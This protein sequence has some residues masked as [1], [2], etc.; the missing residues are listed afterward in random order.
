MTRVLETS[1]PVVL[2]HSL[3][4]G[5]AMAIELIQT[6]QSLGRDKAAAEAG[7]RALKAVEARQAAQHA[8]DADTFWT[9]C[10]TAAIALAEW[11]VGRAG[12]A[13]AAW[14]A[15][16][17][18]RA[19]LSPVRNTAL[20]ALE[21]DLLARSWDIDELAASNEASRA[22][23]VSPRDRG[24][25]LIRVAEA[26]LYQVTDFVQAERYHKMALS[27][28]GAAGDA[29][30][31]PVALALDVHGGR[32][33]DARA[34]VS[35]L[36]DGPAT[37]G[38]CVPVL[39]EAIRLELDKGLDAAALAPQ[40]AAP[41]A[42]LAVLQEVTPPTRRLVLLDGLERCPRW[43]NP[44]TLKEIAALLP[45]VDARG[46]AALLPKARAEGQDPAVAKLRLAE[47]ERVSGRDDHAH[48]LIDQ[49]AD[50]AR[51][52]GRPALLREALRARDRLSWTWEGLQAA[53]ASLAEM[54]KVDPTPA[55]EGLAWLEQAE[56]LVKAAGAAPGQQESSQALDPN[57]AGLCLQW[58]EESLTT[59]AR[60]LDDP[61]TVWKAR[62]ATARARLAAARGDVP[63]TERAADTAA[64]FWRAMGN[65]DAAQ[66]VLS[67]KLAPPPKDVP[68]P[69]VG[70]DSTGR[71][72]PHA[73]LQIQEEQGRRLSLTWLMPDG[74]KLS[75]T[76]RSS[77]M[78]DPATGL[79]EIVAN[80]RG[81]CDQLS[82]L[83]LEG[84]KMNVVVDRP[85][86][87]DLELVTSQRLAWLPWE[88]A[89]LGNRRW[90]PDA[91]VH[92]LWRS[93]HRAPAAVE[94]RGSEPCVVVFSQLVST[95]MR[96][97]E[98][99]TGDV[100]AFYATRGIRVERAEDVGIFQEMLAKLRP[101]VV[102]VTAGLVETRGQAGLRLQEDYYAASKMNI[103][104]NYSYDPFRSLPAKELGR[105]LRKSRAT[106][107]VIL[108]IL[109][110]PVDHEL[111][112]QLRLRN[113]FAAEWADLEPPPAILATGLADWDQRIAL[114]DALTGLLAQDL[115]I[116]EIHR[117]I[118]E[119]LPGPADEAMGPAIRAAGGCAVH[120]ESRPA[121]SARRV[122]RR[123]MNLLEQRAGEVRRQHALLTGE[124]TAW[125]RARQQE[126]FRK[127]PFAGD[128]HR[129]SA[130][131]LSRSQAPASPWRRGQPGRAGDAGRSAA[132]CGPGLGLFSRQVRAARAVDWLAP[133]LRCA[134]ELAW[135]CYKPAREAAVK[136]RDQAMSRALAA[137][138]AAGLTDPVELA[139]LARE[140]AD[141]AGTVD[142]VA[143]K[144]PPLVAFTTDASPYAS[145]RESAV[146]GLTEQDRQVLDEAVRR[147][148]VAVVGVP[149]SYLDHLPRSVSLA[150][151]VGHAV[152]SDLK[153][154][155]DIDLAFGAA[156]GAAFEVD[157]PGAA[158][159]SFTPENR[160]G[161]QAWRHELF[162]DAYGIQCVGAAAVL[163]LADFL[164]G[165]P[166]TL[167]KQRQGPPYRPHPPDI[168]R[169]KV[170]LALL[171]SAGADDAGLAAAWQT[172]Y[173]FHQMAAFEAD[174]PAVVT[175]LLDTPLKALGGSLREALPFGPA[176]RQRVAD[177]RD[178]LA[179]NRK[180]SP[181]TVF[182]EVLAA[183]AELYYTDA[184]AY[185]AADAE[186]PLFARFQELI[187]PGPRTEPS[188]AEKKNTAAYDRAAGADLIAL[189]E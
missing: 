100:A 116:G 147:L 75:R 62:I 34:K 170:N 113:M 121:L 123:G 92:W 131:G 24:L 171:A 166:G 133:T 6:L 189:P 77:A 10:L 162:A 112:D 107:L 181:F 56:R 94:G 28:L 33:A 117:A 104:S 47:L 60:L 17:R 16:G 79:R 178:D 176:A 90:P 48:R 179:N 70:P 108:D 167:G 184:D 182:R 78:T 36:L 137:R 39:L 61:V 38:A 140:D 13:L 32:L 9:A 172:A 174:I 8:P 156:F 168:L 46:L 134:D 31:L 118:P 74:L 54:W 65:D 163:A 126:R 51:R 153:V 73:V 42:L 158:A 64:E 157:P 37:V 4:G 101:R 80:W 1:Y 175:A 72:A 173:P 21:Q 139:R 129:G 103:Q 26:Y 188:A 30:L 19:R 52:T 177:L 71:Q 152:S 110:P 93:M 89:L 68:V 59:A 114:L 96:G 125:R 22:V 55:L 41:A 130:P 91:G 142:A 20:S 53:Q 27:E 148:P 124:L 2:Q 120:V 76:P 161:W 84:P 141:Q 11:R 81:A 128:A 183:G 155:G 145:A 35:T 44:A 88:M 40:A 18:G 69:A 23:A 185:A 132:G 150:H 58:A 135:S 87:M 45:R 99:D 159:R 164:A 12:Q 151:E 149:W 102:H 5:A 111:V 106:P 15:P 14:L 165:D 50:D 169:M 86:S 146:E 25:R 109:A 143:L 187:K 67:V 43:P 82:R 122:R 95:G 83:V 154:R 144:E 98:S 7:A 105:M 49:A 66:Q 136:A 115:P 160:A 57:A 63:A 119:H 97:L 186:R 127:T 3:D 85:E 29:A 180:L 138:V